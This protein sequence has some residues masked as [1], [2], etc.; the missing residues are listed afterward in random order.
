MAGPSDRSGGG[1]GSCLGRDG[2]PLRADRL[3]EH[4]HHRDRIVLGAGHEQRTALLSEPDRTVFPEIAEVAARR[5]EVR[6]G[7]EAK[8]RR[9]RHGTVHEVLGQRDRRA[10]GRRR[11]CDEDSG[12]EASWRLPISSGPM[13]FLTP[14]QKVST[15]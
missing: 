9:E 1:G 5:G 3:L 2:K 15:R 6:M 11:E 7:I 8:A 13:T 14:R 10:Q 4:A 12:E